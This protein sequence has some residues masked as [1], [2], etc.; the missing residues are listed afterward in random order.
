MM[1]HT[2]MLANISDSSSM[3]T[4]SSYFQ[5]SNYTSVQS[6]QAGFCFVLSFGKKGLPQEYTNQLSIFSQLPAQI[7]FKQF[8]AYQLL[9]VFVV[10]TLS[11]T[12][13][14]YSLVTTP[15]I[16][17]FSY[18]MFYISVCKFS[19]SPL[20]EAH[21]S[22]LSYSPSYSMTQEFFDSY[23]LLG[24]GVHQGCIMS[25]CLFNFYAEYIMRNAGLE[26]S[27]SWNQDCREKYQ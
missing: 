6:Y 8:A 25:P 3:Y 27:T 16:L 18:C 5:G 15:L 14:Y 26:G 23:R 24:K 20:S 7:Y 17:F 13:K 21:E 11:S 19:L 10:T 22:S 2:M 9:Y 1:L 12:T 4:N